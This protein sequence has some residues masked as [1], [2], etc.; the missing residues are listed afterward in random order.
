[1]VQIIEKFLAEAGEGVFISCRSEE[2]SHAA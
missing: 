1:M 2:S